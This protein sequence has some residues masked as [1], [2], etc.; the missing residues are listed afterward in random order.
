[1]GIGLP[2]IPRKRHA[3]LEL[4]VEQVNSKIYARLSIV[5][6]CKIVSAVVSSK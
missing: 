2:D 4:I 1:M 6:H 3:G 5:L